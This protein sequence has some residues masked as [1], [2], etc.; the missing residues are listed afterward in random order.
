[1]KKLSPPRGRD[2]FSHESYVGAGCDQIGK[3]ERD[4]RRRDE[5]GGGKSMV[6]T[7]KSCPPPADDAHLAG[8]EGR[9]HG[10]AANVIEDHDG[11]AA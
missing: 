11:A 10:H 9:W 5:G 7:M 3:F 2:D 4:R 8:A 6:M 1:M